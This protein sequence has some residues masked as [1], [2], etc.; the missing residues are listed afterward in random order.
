MAK[1]GTLVKKI[2]ILLIARRIRFLGIAIGTGIILIYSLGLFVS[3]NY[4]NN[5]LFH[6]NIL[7]LVLTAVLCFPSFFIKKFLF[8]KINSKNF[9]TAYFNA[10]IVPFA[11]CD[12]GGLFCITTNLFV[13]QNIIY[14][15]A[16]LAVALL[17]LIINFPGFNDYDN[18]NLER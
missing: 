6:F 8:K 3:G 18:L 9:A 16:G 2:D 12:L 11:L 14:A 17:F 7:S 10:H 13:N 1:N 4:I 5:E 15:T